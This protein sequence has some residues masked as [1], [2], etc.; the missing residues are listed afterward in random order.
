MKPWTLLAEMKLAAKAELA[1]I[2]GY[3]FHF[4]DQNKRR[5]STRLSSCVF[6]VNRSIAEINVVTAS[7]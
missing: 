6:G 2:E 4:L 5:R 7:L 1:K 3:L